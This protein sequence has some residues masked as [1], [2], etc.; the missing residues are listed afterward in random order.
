M[1]AIDR[2]VLTAD[3][4]APAV[5]AG[6]ET[7]ALHRFPRGLGRIGVTDVDWAAVEVLAMDGIDHGTDHTF[8][9][10]AFTGIAF[11]QYLGVHGF[12]AIADHGEIV[13]DDAG[14]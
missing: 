1:P 4:P 5:V 9:A 6:L 10:D 12:A 8:A 3:F 11:G 7:Q 13:G 2:D 14:R